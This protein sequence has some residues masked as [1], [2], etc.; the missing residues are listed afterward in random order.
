MIFGD[1]NR[2][3]ERER[4]IE[5]AVS[6]WRPRTPDGRILAHPS[7]ADLPEADRLRAHDETLRAR[8]LE[9]LIDRQGLSTTVRAVLR[10]IGA[11]PD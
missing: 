8:A 9:G 1:R 7:W 3:R 11:R 2:E 10:R 5:E 6:A 4:L